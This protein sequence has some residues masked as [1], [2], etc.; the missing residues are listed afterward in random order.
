MNYQDPEFQEIMK[1]IGDIV[2]T[3]A[4]NYLVQHPK[5]KKLNVDLHEKE[6][7]HICTITLARV[8]KQWRVKQV[9]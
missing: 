6:G 3:H 5:T 7:T 2:F 8:K 4:D 1:E 9:I